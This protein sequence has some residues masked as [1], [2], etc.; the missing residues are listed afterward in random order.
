MVN[1]ATLIKGDFSSKE[2][3]SK[4]KKEVQDKSLGHPSLVIAD[5]PHHLEM[6]SFDT[7][8]SEWKKKEFKDLFQ[9]VN[10][11]VGE[12]NEFPTVVIHSSNEMLHFVLSAATEAKYKYQVCS[13]CNLH[14]LETV[15]E[16]EKT[17][18]RQDDISYFT[19]CWKGIDTP[20]CGTTHEMCLR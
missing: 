8:Q 10:G 6:D 14:D 16:M 15:S 17:T 3:A 2:A 18:F 12:G 1:H 9:F 11:L 20:F 5:A 19:V 4:V 7:L 13:F